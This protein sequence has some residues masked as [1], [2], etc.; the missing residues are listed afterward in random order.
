MKGDFSMP[1]RGD[2]THKR[3]DGRW[4]GRYKIGNY[5][6]GATKYNSVYGHSYNEVK[7]K[8]ISIGTNSYKENLSESNSLFET[9][10][11]QL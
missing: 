10:I 3:K 2:R 7:D 11:Y 1:K 8:L 4:E 5:P 6:S 9:I